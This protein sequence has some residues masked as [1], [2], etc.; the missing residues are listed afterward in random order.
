MNNFI[1]K[2]YILSIEEINKLPKEVD[3]YENIKK[4]E[5]K[6]KEE[7]KKI[8]EKDKI[9]N[10]DE[11]EELFFPETEKEYDFFISYS[12]NDEDT[13]RKLAFYLEKKGFKVFLDSKIWGAADYLL[14]LIDKTYSISEQDNKLF[15]YRKRNFSTSHI[16]S[17][18]NSAIG[19]AILRSKNI[20]FTSIKNTSN[21]NL[22]TSKLE[23][24]ILS[25]WIYQ[26]LGYFNLFND[27]Q[28]NLIKFYEEKVAL[29]SI[30]DKVEKKLI[31][32]RTG[33]ISKLEKITINYLINNLIKKKDS[34]H[35]LD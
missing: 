13:V 11:L 18:L 31:I 9:I 1:K 14:E 19:K 30:Q 27:L 23:V 6:L 35:F 8:F 26:E 33:D 5:K 17:M 3:R 22:S 28:S 15:D 12:H 20:I 29:E 24:K 25:P 34:L 32:S 2:G 21:I 4:N 7:V 10:G 16:H